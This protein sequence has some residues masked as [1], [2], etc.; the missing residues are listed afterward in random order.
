[1]PIFEKM[2]LEE[3][4][5]QTKPFKNEIQKLILNIN[6]TSSWLNGIA[7]EKLK[8]FDISAPQYNVLRILKGRYPESYC[9][10]EITARMIDKNSN[11]TRIVDKLIAKSLVKRSENPSDRRA[12]E[13]FI[14]DKGLALLEEINLSAFGSSDNFIQLDEIK[15]KQMNDWLDELRS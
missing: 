14:T 3:E 6:F 1:V 12:V 8:P 7:A 5:K 9:N 15:A 2:K 13:I 11:A 10:Q 4:L